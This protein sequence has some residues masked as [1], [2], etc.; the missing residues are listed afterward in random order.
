MTNETCR[1]YIYKQ[2]WH[3]A[4]GL[5]Y[6]FENVPGLISIDVCPRCE[7]LIKAGAI[8]IERDPEEWAGN[9]KATG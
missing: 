3:S 1:W 6:K 8:L 2:R 7:K 9:E 5:A 4:C